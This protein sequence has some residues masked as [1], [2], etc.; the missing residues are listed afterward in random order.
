MERTRNAMIKTFYETTKEV[1]AQMQIDSI[2]QKAQNAKAATLDIT[3]A[4]RRV[5][6]RWYSV[7]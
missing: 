7:W 5:N 4:F 3:S 2:N 6:L 1:E